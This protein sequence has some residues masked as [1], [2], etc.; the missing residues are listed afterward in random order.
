MESFWGETFAMFKLNFL[1][2]YSI[3][4]TNCI[5]EMTISFIYFRFCGNELTTFNQSG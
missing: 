2:K 4:H 5:H 1:G 3:F